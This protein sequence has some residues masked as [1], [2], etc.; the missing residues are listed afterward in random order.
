MYDP[1]QVHYASAHTP[2]YEILN[3]EQYAQRYG[4][5]VSE[6]PLWCQVWLRVGKIL[7][8]IG[9]KLTAENTPIHLNKETV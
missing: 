8:R 9:E 6:N 1:M 4:R 7:I 2:P 5:V 3:E